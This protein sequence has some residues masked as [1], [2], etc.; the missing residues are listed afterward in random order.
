MKTKAIIVLL[1][2]ITTLL[3]VSCV[4]SLFTGKTN[5]KFVEYGE[6]T[7]IYDDRVKITPLS[8][9]ELSTIV[10]LFENKRLYKDR[11]SCGFS[12]NISIKFNSSQTFCIAR[13][14]C[15]IIYW[16][17]KNLYF[18][19]SEDEKT[20]LYDILNSHGFSFPCV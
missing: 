7:L 15:P 4:I 10:S 14:T 6:A 2:G 9:Q 13:D 12:E 5:L 18:K 11:L 17:E 8:D 3:I 20:I 16:A 19:I 1:A